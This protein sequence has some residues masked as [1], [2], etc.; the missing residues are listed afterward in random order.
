MRLPLY[1]VDA[2]TDRLFG[3]NPAAVVPLEEWLPEATMQAIAME[4][5]LSETAFFVREGEGYGL[6]WFTPVAEIDL[7]GHPTLATA[8]VIF[9]FIKPSA[10]ELT[11]RTMKAGT[12]VVTRRGEELAM[13][14]PARPPEPCAV[15]PTLAPAL[16]KPPIKVL[17]SRDYMAVYQSAA[18]VA[19]LKPD[20]GAIAKL[21]RM[22]VIATAPGEGEVDF[23]SR[24]F[25]P[26]HNINEDPVT[27]SA[28]CTLIP[29][30]AER[31]GKTRLKAQQISARIGDLSCEHRGERV[32]IAGRCVLYMEGTI[33]L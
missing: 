17:A 15:P 11:F 10:L 22:A 24:F 25:A 7:A 21:D 18:D 32:T 5:N 23:V 3:G 29:F 4:N 27:G 28:H 26:A 30:W 14:F 9:R 19:A 16:G 33:T 6:R 2:F 13:D 1:Q 8:Y 12:L 20:F 31:L